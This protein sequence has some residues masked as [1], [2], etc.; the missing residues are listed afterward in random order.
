MK[1][2]KNKKQLTAAEI[3]IKAEG[4]EFKN[5]K[6]RAISAAKDFNYGDDV[7]ASLKA[8]TTSYQVETIMKTARVAF[9]EARA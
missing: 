1:K 7:V 3:A 6:T 8:A 9:W 5:Y 4:R 2:V